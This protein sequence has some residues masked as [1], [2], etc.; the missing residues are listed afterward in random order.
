MATAGMAVRNGSGRDWEKGLGYP[1]ERPEDVAIPLTDATP[2]QQT[3]ADYQVQH[4][5]LWLGLGG[6]LLLNVLLVGGMIVQAAKFKPGLEYVTLDG[7][8]I[9]KWKEN[10]TPEIDGVRYVPA[11]MRAA[12]TTFVQNRYEYDWQNLEKL[13]KALAL[14]PEDAAKEERLKIRD[15]SPMTNIVAPHLKVALKMDWSKLEVVAQGKGIFEVRVGGMAR[16]NN[17]TRFPDPNNPL[18]KPVE[19][20]LIVRTVE[21]TDTN[22]LGY[23]ITST[24]QKDPVL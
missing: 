18:E 21:A 15:L 2:E 20:K 19:V 7:G 3:L 5:R 9:V 10:A 22:P 6:S 24:S 4:N 11:R 16:I 13:Y 8:Y 1:G 12:V 23:V 14:M 17:L